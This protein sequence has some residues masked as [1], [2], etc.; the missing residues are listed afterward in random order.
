LFTK[1]NPDIL[2]LFVRRSLWE[3]YRGRRSIEIRKKGISLH[4]ILRVLSEG[5]PIRVCD[6]KVFAVDR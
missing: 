3:I 6:M 4:R 2:P 1:T 5:G